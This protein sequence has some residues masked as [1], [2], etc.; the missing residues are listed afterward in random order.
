VRYLDEERA[1]VV[2][3]GRFRGKIE[4]EDAPFFVETYDPATGVIALS[5]TTEEPIAAE[6]LEVREDDVLYCR[7]KGRFPARFTRAA[8]AALLLAVDV[9]GAAFTLRLGDRVLPLVRLATNR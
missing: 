7:V 1:W 3:L 5:D 6:T 4:L 8:Q 2:Q 9:E